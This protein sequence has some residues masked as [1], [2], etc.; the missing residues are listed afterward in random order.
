M[1]THLFIKKTGKAAPQ[2][3][4]HMREAHGSDHTVLRFAGIQRVF[5]PINGLD[6]HTVLLQLES[7]WI[8]KTMGPLDINDKIELS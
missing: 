1:G 2:L 7:K 3:I 5:A 8:F 6:E 4:S